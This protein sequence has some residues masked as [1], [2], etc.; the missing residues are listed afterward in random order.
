MNPSVVSKLLD[1]NREFYQTFGP[2]FAA[3]RRR[4][5]PG[6]SRVIASLPVGSRLLDLGCGSGAL[7]LELNRVWTSGSYHGIDSSKELLEA[8]RDALRKVPS[9]MV[10]ISFARADLADPEWVNTIRGQPVDAC[11]AFAVLHHLPGSELREQVLRQVA[12]VLEEGRLF[13][14]SEWQFHHSPKLMAR[15]Q[16]WS[17]A[18]LSDGDVDPGDYLLDW[19]YAMP[20]QPEQAGLRYVH[21]FSLEELSDLAAKTGFEVKYSFESDGEGRK[22]GLYQMWVKQQG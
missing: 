15:V 14:H 1:L 7:A 17:A 10:A 22:L 18:G 8:A 6:M 21:L 2:A 4:I 11:L 9:G 12:G 19:R 16:P 13:V 5:Q 3:T 20:G